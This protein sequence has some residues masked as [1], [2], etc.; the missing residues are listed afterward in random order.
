MGLSSS[1]KGENLVWILQ[2]LFKDNAVSELR[3]LRASYGTFML[4]EP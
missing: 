3:V 1:K 4:G 2:L